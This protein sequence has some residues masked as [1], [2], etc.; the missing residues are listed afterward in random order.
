MQHTYITTDQEQLRILA[1]LEAR[2]FV[3]SVTGLHAGPTAVREPLPKE[4]IITECGM[5]H[6]EDIAKLPP[7]ASATPV[8]SYDPSDDM[9]RCFS[10]FQLLSKLLDTGWEHQLVRRNHCE[11]YTTEGRRIFIVAE[12]TSA[13]AEN[14]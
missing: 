8:L 6:I 14:I 2:L 4:W 11:P 9:T 12:Q 13:F 3:K 5:D 7:S 10:T 1:L